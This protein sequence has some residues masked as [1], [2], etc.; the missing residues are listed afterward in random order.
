VASKALPSWDEDSPQLRRNL[1]KVSVSIERDAANRV[2]PKVAAA[3]RWQAQIMAGLAVDKPTY[4][5]RFRGERGLERCGVHVDGANGSAP[6]N[7][8]GELKAFESILQRAVAG[9]D[10]KYPDVESLDEDGQSAVIE[11]AAWAHAE[12]TRIHPF[13]NG[14]GRTAR[15]WANLVL[16]RY[17]L[18]PAVTLRPRPGSGYAAAGA[19]AMRGQWRPTVSLFRQLVRG[20]LSGQSATAAARKKPKPA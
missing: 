10:A 9:L 3:K 16:M 1:G 19:A 8:A 7:V 4:V 6:W 15:V 12:W 11:L 2:L 18:P 14:N 17:G 13:A 20:F 5:G